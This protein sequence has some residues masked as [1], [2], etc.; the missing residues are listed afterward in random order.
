MQGVK[1]A[2]I[3][4]KMLTSNFGDISRN[5]ALTKERVFE[6]I[7]DEFDPTTIDIPEEYNFIIDFANNNLYDENHDQMTDIGAIFLTGKAG[8]G[9]STA[10]KY[11]KHMIKNSVVI[12]PTTIAAMNVKGSTIHSFFG[13]VPGVMDPS[14]IDTVNQKIVPVLH[15]LDLLIVDEISMV[16]SAMVDCMDVALRLAKNIDKPF[17]GIKML[18][19]GDLFQLPPIVEDE[20]VRKYFAGTSER[21]DSEFFISADVFKNKTGGCNIYSLEL[22]VVKRQDVSLGNDNAEFVKALNAIRTNDSDHIFGALHFINEKCFENKKNVHDI[23]SGSIAL[24]P[25]KARAK[26]FNKTQIDRLE[27]ELTMYKGILKGGMSAEMIKQFQAPDELELKV[28][29]QVVFVTNNKPEWINGQLG[30]VEELGKD[31][32]KVKTL[33][34]GFVR[35]VKRESFNKY[36]YKYDIQTKYLSRSSIEAFVQFPLALGWAITIHKSQGMTLENVIV[37]IKKQAFAEGQTYVALSRV[38]SIDGLILRSQ[39]EYGDIKVNDQVLQIYSEL[40][41][42]DYRYEG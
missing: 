21:Y 14:E 26:E 33:K 37:D 41:P 7:D 29:A 36:T 18:F 31:V 35:S 10:I 12:A 17:G 13:F 4:R 6:K 9:K 8:T 11:V 23:Q 30:V 42:D 2:T 34:D 25:T 1:M 28:G 22:K 24:V 32:I 16:S 40:F 20:E 27:G 19:V 38:K 15:A 5:I 39:L 3:Q